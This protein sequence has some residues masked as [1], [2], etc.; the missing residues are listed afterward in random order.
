MVLK[1]IVVRDVARGFIAPARRNVR[2]PRVYTSL[3]RPFRAGRVRANR[4]RGEDGDKGKDSGGASALRDSE[5]SS[6]AAEQRRAARANVTARIS[7]A[8]ALAQRLAQEKAAAAS[9]ARASQD[10]GGLDECEPLDCP[11]FTSA[12]AAQDDAHLQI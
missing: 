1:G 8:R 11:P 7:A 12:G 6:I 5:E 4:G 2:L 3:C 9:A 10:S